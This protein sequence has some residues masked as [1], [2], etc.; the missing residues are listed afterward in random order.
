[1]FDL[2]WDDLEAEIPDEG[3]NPFAVG[4]AMAELVT[5]VHVTADHASDIR[6]TSFHRAPAMQY[7]ASL[8]E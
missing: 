3:P 2:V 7:A 5:G 1:L 6:S 8:D 4:L